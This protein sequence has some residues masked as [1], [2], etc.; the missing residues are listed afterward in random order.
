MITKLPYYLAAEIRLDTIQINKTIL[1]ERKMLEYLHIKQKSIT[2]ASSKDFS[3][4]LS[5]AAMAF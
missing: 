5:T 2:F 1:L 3:K 4:Q